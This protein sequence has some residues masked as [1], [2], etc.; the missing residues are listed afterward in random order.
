MNFPC[1]CSYSE[2]SDGKMDQ[3]KNKGQKSVW[4]FIIFTGPFRKYIDNRFTMVSCDYVTEAA[5]INEIKNI[6]EPNKT[7]MVNH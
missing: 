7:V 4:W 5:N 3:F 1:L 2:L 6:G